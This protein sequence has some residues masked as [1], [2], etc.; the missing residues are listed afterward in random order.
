M[1]QTKK[2]SFGSEVARRSVVEGVVLEG[3]RSVK[4][5]A[6]LREARL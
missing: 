2:L 4:L 5:E 3:A 1:A 6:E